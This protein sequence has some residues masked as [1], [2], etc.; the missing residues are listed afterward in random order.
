MEEVL[1]AVNPTHVAYENYAMSRGKSGSRVFDIG[2]LGGVYKTLLWERGVDIVLVSITSMKLLIAGYGKAEKQHI[3]AAILRDF[4][5]RIQQND[6]ADAA[7]LLLVGECRCGITTLPQVMANSSYR[8]KIREIEV[9][10]GRMQS[11]AKVTR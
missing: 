3:T 11:V 9:L 2:E 5:Q 1:D 7:G 4:G 8:Q 6:E 10:P